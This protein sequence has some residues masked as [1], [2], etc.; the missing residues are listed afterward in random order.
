ME[1]LLVEERAARTHAI[2]RNAALLDDDDD[3]DDEDTLQVCNDSSSSSVEIPS[4]EKQGEKNT[5]EL[6]A[7]E[8]ME[9]VESMNAISSQLPQSVVITPK[10]PTNSL[11]MGDEHLSTIPEKESDEF[12]KFSVEDLVPIPSE[13]RGILDQ[14]CDSPSPPEI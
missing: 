4:V 1:E 14:M 10:D 11:S 7:E 6:L 9:L 12:I 5:E 2:F 3:S 13:F 8:Q